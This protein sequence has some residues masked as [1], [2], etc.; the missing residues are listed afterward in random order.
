MKTDHK[1]IAETINPNILKS[2]QSN[3]EYKAT[4]SHQLVRWPVMNTQ[5]RHQFH[6]QVQTVS[7]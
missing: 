4:E 2:S 3:A 5:R 7:L 6:F 1:G